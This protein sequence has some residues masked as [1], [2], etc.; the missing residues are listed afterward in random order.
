M[1]CRQAPVLVVGQPRS[2]S[3]ITT[4]VLNE[5]EGTFLLNDFYALQAIDAEGLWDRRDSAS[6]ARVAEI[7]LDRLSIRATQEAGKTLEQSIDLSPEG[8]VEVAAFA[9]RDWPDGTAWNE[10]VGGVLQ[11]A[12]KAAGC[13]AWGWNTPQ[14]HLHLGR[15]F[16]A[17]P[18]AR[19]V[20]VLRTPSA[21]LRSYKNVSGPWHDVRRYNPVTIGLAWKVAALNYHRWRAVKPGQVEFLRYEELVAETDSS[22]ARLAEFVDR[23]CP[24][25]DLARF[26]KNS[27]HGAGR[28]SRGV[29][30]AEVWLAQKIIGDD[31]ARLGFAPDETAGPTSGLFQ[32]ARILTRS[33]LFIGSQVL[34]DPDRRRRALNFLRR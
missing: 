27:S 20:F 14:D 32:L 13:V 21:V 5:C 8:L 28:K 16:S 1:P 22:V 31:L 2:G 33:G 34:T 10:V 19:V 7:V 12:A 15:V 30:A 3:T 9:G 18:D 29:S 26:G 23:P 11:C 17:W 24:A 4:R 6:A 25:I